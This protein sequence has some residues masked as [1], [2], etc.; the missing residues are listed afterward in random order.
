MV[1][2]TT[3][4]VIGLL[5]FGSLNTLTTKIQFELTS[6]GLDGNVK[7]FK[8]PWFGTLTMFLGMTIV[9]LIHF[10][11]VLIRRSVNNSEKSAPFLEAGVKP[12]KVP[13]FWE[14]AKLIALP[15]M[16]DLVATVLCFV[17]LLYNSAS[18]WQMLRGSM[19]IF[20][21][22]LSVI[23]LK[24]KL[25]PYHW[26]AVAVCSAAIVIVGY[27]NMKAAA[28]H[29]AASATSPGMVV[30]GMA[31]IVIGQVIQAS[32]V[33]TEERLLKGCSIEPFQIVGMEG[34]WGSLAMIFIFFPILYL[35]PGSDS[36]SAES[37]S[38]TFTMLSN[39][40]QLLWLVGLYVFSVFTYNMSGMLVTYALSAVHRTM[41]EASRT[42]IIWI[43]DLIVHYL[44]SPDSSFGE[45]WTNWSWLQLFGFALLILGQ[46]IYSELVRVPGFYYPP[47]PIVATIESIQA[48]PASVRY[49]VMIPGEEVQDGE[50]IMVMENKKN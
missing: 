41:L 28:G 6:V 36:G 33:V 35:L 45:V 17:G 44:I 8:K 14:A 21:A 48:S 39:N 26:F 30:F 19:I 18:I 47:R 31:L 9:L 5:V 29:P 27:A 32:Q 7:H 12:P 37:I 15:A 24:R 46:S 43:F 10:V 11:N 38:D 40:H 16:L 42:A 3:L 22:I 1:S 25:H 20:S 34:V 2:K 4:Y 49:N 13:S 50:L 23:F